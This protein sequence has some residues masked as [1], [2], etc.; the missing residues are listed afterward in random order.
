[1]VNDHLSDLITRIR[2][3]YIAH[4]ETV[5]MPVTKSVQRVAEVLKKQGYLGEVTLKDKDLVLTLK[6]SGK[7]PAISGIKR[8]S[9]PGARVYCGVKDF[10]KVLGGLGKNILSTPKGIMSDKEAR[11]LKVGGEIIAQVW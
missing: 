5:D 3:G 6:Y 2:N 1:M 4:R 7:D 10:P 9:K 8:V 11:K